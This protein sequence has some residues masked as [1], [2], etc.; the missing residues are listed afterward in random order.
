MKHKIVPENCEFLLDSE[1][2][3]YGIS[4]K[5]TERKSETYYMIQ[6][7]F[8]GSIIRRLYKMQPFYIYYNKKKFCQTYEISKEFDLNYIII[9]YNNYKLSICCHRSAPL[10]KSNISVYFVSCF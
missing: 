3:I 4:F 1:N 6:N 10:N 9:L 2:R 5:L 7:N 8:F